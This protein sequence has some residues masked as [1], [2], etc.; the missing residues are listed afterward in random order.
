[1]PSFQFCPH[2]AAPLIART[3]QGEA[4]RVCAKGCGFVH[5]D[6]PTPG[7]A[8][9]VEHDGKVVLAHNRAW[10]PAFRPFFGLITEDGR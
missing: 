7:V 10:P 2:C 4:R 3:V 1:M 9:V 8:A 5:Y 6:N